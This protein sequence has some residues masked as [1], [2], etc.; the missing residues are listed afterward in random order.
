MAQSKPLLR[1]VTPLSDEQFDTLERLVEPLSRDQV[2]WIGG[3]LAGIAAT[4]RDALPANVVD[5][6]SDDPPLTIV[7]GSQS[8]NGARIADEARAQAAKKGFRARVKAMDEYRAADL[9]GEKNLLL[10]VS[11]HGE[12]EP[13]DSAK[14]LFEFVHGRKAG[15]LDNTRY[16]VL[17]LGDTS[18]EHFCKTG[19]DFDARLQALGAQQVHPRAE[20]DVDY[21]ETAAQWIEHALNAL[22]SHAKPRA[23]TAVPL[24]APYAKVTPLYSRKNP[25]L[26]TMLT[27]I[28][29]S[30]HGSAKEVRHIE[31][32]LDGSAI[33]YEPGD[34]LAVIPTNEREVVEDILDALGLDAAASVELGND[35]TTVEAALT[36]SCEITTLTRPVVEKYAAMSDARD[37]RELLRDAAKLRDYL[38]GRHLVD[39][40]RQ[41][42]VRGLGANEL[43]GMLRKL[44][45]RLYSIASSHKASPG[46]VHATVAAVRFESHGRKRKGVASTFVAERM[47][48]GDS[49]PIY[50]EANRNFKLPADA[51]TPIIMV[52][53]GTG[54]APFRAFMQ[55]REAIGARGRNWLFFGD[56][57]FTTDFLYQREW[58]HYLKDGI[59]TRMN[60]AFSRDR[61]DKVYVQ[62]RMM[63]EARDLYTWLQEG[64]HFYVC[65]DAEHMARDVHRTLTEIVAEQGNLS[66][67][68][69]TEYV[70]DLQ[71][72]RRYQR[73]VY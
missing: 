50:V 55:E 35:E 24:A 54:V 47:A 33:G 73:D 6:A 58:Q 31:L 20:C 52:G 46:E 63:D 17:A 71:R 61:A 43:V 41:F 49:I 25:F 4:R 44:P 21:D 69:A 27:N 48:E 12:G 22:A 1:Q 62:H 66:S 16:S 9:K 28:N 15:R 14:E 39:L 67:E 8:G 32:S 7:Y 2:V 10:I 53:P 70:Q 29:L 34:S 59:L 11:T 13:P 45:A 30:G 3:Y 57:H 40:V 38:Y 26:A 18:Y 68:R 37:L 51:A 19:R 64:A 65:G 72:A 56:R 5:L 23:A 60:V 36:N 42:P